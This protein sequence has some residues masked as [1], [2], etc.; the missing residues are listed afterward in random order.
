MGRG[1]NVP[2]I[3]VDGLNYSRYEKQMPALAEF[4]VENNIVFTSMIFYT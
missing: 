4:R 1:Q 2:A 3:T